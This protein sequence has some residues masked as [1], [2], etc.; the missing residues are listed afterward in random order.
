M[1]CIASFFVK[2]SLLQ[3][4]LYLHVLIMLS[5]PSTSTS[6]SFITPTSFL[7]LCQFSPESKTCQQHCT[8]RQ[9]PPPTQRQPHMDDSKTPS[10]PEPSKSNDEPNKKQSSSSPPETIPEFS[11]ILSSRGDP[12]CKQCEGRGEISCPVCASQG[13]V[14]MKMFD[15][16]STV[17][18]RLCRGKVRIPCPSCRSMIYKSVL[19][20][21]QIP[22][23][24]PE[25]KWR[26]GEDGQPRIPWTPPPA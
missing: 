24:D 26:T 19:W 11:Q 23:D 21:D 22:K 18:C 8:L 9:R 12:S 2:S 25:D 1:E 3:E 20:W 7:Q 13:F 10:P 5:S 17:Q 14:S 4:T 15:T 16:V 6:P